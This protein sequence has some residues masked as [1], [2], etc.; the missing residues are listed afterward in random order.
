MCIKVGL[1]ALL[2]DD[3]SLSSGYKEFGLTRVRRCRW[4]ALLS[5]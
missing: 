4:A 5:A 1:L 2:V 3:F